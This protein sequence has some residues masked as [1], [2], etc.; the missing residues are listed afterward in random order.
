MG[1]SKLGLNFRSA[2]DYGLRARPVKLCLHAL[3]QESCCVQTRL[4]VQNVD[5]SLEFWL[6]VMRRIHISPARVVHRF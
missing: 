3:G 5:Q 1:A 4:E 2:I 6:R